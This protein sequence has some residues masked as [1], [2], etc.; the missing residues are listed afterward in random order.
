MDELDQFH[1]GH[2]TLL[3]ALRCHSRADE[4]HAHPE[5]TWTISLSSQPPT[6]AVT[7]SH[8]SAEHDGLREA[9][10]LTNGVSRLAV[11]VAMGVACSTPARDERHGRGWPAGGRP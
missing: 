6:G 3:I 2:D 9:D 8:A 7:H 1:Y 11:T 4:G 10:S 5:G